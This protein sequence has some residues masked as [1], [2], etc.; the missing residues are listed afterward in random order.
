M[1]HPQRP[2]HVPAR[3]TKCGL[4][5]DPCLF[6]V[7]PLESNGV[8]ART[9]APKTKSPLARG[10][11]VF[12]ELDGL[13]ES[14]RS[15]LISVGLARFRPR[16][17]RNCAFLSKISQLGSGRRYSLDLE[18]CPSPSPRRL[19]SSTGWTQWSRSIR[20]RSP[21]NPKRG[22][23][24]SSRSGSQSVKMVSWTHPGQ[25]CASGSGRPHFRVGGRLEV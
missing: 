5:G 24:R 15:N 25:P 17:T 14:N 13:W 16:G 23:Q 18:A 2:G 11:F 1:V 9:A 3:A 20:D 8:R 12:Y 19:A 6:V 21:S 4:D 10:G 7:R 22:L